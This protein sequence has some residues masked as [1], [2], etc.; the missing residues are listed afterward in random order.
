MRYIICRVVVDLKHGL[1][2]LERL[3]NRCLEYVVNLECAK[4]EQKFGGVF[5]FRSCVLKTCDFQFV[6]VNF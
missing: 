4:L 2:N 6:V 5:S 1:E 3:M